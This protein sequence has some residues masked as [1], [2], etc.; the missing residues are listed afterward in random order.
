M[1]KNQ[2]FEKQQLFLK[3]VKN[4]R[5]QDKGRLNGYLSVKS[6]EYSC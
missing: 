2:N 4:I 5:K 1:I 6:E 3:M